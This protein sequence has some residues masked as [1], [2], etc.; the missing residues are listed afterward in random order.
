MTGESTD[1][2]HAVVQGIVQGVGF[3]AFVIA[4]AQARHLTGWVRNTWDGKVEVLAEGPR[5]TLEDLLT[6]LRRGPRSAVVY[7]VT[8]EWVAARG[9]Y[10]NFS[11]RRSV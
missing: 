6:T 10:T 3:R 11:M 9:E 8:V 5:T 1:G 4:E 7:A 2:L